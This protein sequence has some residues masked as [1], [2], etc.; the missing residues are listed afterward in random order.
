[1]KEADIVRDEGSTTL[2]HVPH[3]PHPPHLPHL[4]YLPH[5]PMKAQS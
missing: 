1:M 5:P 4:P 3:L 2:P